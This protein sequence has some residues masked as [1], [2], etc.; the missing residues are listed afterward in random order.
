MTDLIPTQ[1]DFAIAPSALGGLVVTA[2]GR[3]PL[4]DPADAVPLVR[5]RLPAFVDV[6]WSAARVDHLRL[7]RRHRYTVLL[8]A[9]PPAVGEG[10]RGLGLHRDPDA[11]ATPDE[12]DRAIFAAAL[13]REKSGV[14]DLLF[15]GLL[16]IVRGV[17]TNDERGAVLAGARARVA[18]LAASPTQRDPLLA[19]LVRLAERSTTLN[20]TAPGLGGPQ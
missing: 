1:F 17:A 5:D 9:A 2:E 14:P 3:T 20:Q 13:E 19:G 15:S 8:P 4:A 11:E 7:G 10:A 6:D 18:R 16:D 12:V